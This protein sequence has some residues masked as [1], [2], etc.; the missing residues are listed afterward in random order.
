MDETLNGLYSGMEEDD[1]RSHEAIAKS[2]LDILVTGKKKLG[3]ALVVGK[4]FH[5][6]SLLGS[7]YAKSVWVTLERKCDF[8]L[9]KDKEY[10]KA[11]SIEH[12]NRQVINPDERDLVVRMFNSLSKFEP[13]QR[14]MSKPDGH[15]EVSLFTRL[16]EWDHDSKA[17]VDIY[18]PGACIIDLKTTAYT[19]SD[20]FSKAI[21]DYGYAAQAGYYTNLVH[22]IRDVWL[23]FL[24]FCTSKRPPYD[25]W[26]QVV[27]WD[28]IHHGFKW[29]ND[30]YRVWNRMLQEQVHA[31]IG[32]AESVTIKETK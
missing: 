29:C 4:A 8:R 5:D 24:F 13:Y 14:A 3:R 2:D 30:I 15:Q 28:H 10:A 20:E 19:T 16:P 31:A 17:R 23:P 27:S 21:V 12:G 1:Y 18:V 7:D 9:K 26:A 11:F 6:L 22:S 32:D 25:T